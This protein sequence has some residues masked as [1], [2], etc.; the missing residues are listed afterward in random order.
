MSDGGYANDEGVTL[1]EHA[2]AFRKL[3]YLALLL[4]LVVGC[5]FV[6]SFKVQKQQQ[7][8]NYVKQRM[9][10]AQTAYQNQAAQ[11][12]ASNSYLP[13]PSSAIQGPMLNH[14]ALVTDGLGKHLNPTQTVPASGFDVYYFNTQDPYRAVHKDNVQNIALTINDNELYDI[15]TQFMGVYWVGTVYAP[16][17]GMYDIAVS[18]SN[19][20][21]RALLDGRVIEEDTTHGALGAYVYLNQGYYKFELEFKNNY[22][23]VD[24][25]AYFKKHSQ[26]YKKEALVNALSGLGIDNTTPLYV[27]SVGRAKNND[28]TIAV[29]SAINEPYVLMLS[30]PMG[31]LWQVYGQPP[32]AIIHN[33]RN[34]VQSLGSPYL[35]ESAIHLDKD[36][37]SEQVYCS[38]SDNYVFYCS[39]YKDLKQTMA[40]I[41]QWTGLNLVG[42]KSDFSADVIFLPDLAVNQSLIDKRHQDFLKQQNQC[43]PPLQD[44]RPVYVDP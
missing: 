39:D 32:R 34:Q 44:V 4:S 13:V 2:S 22:H 3:I 17:N 10:A 16:T 27:V 31:T 41:N 29:H 14:F 18:S 30:A 21:V 7:Q 40:Q 1:W 42:G 8:L 28:K 36:I 23:S 20:S 35:L 5:G 37:L 25:Y 19:S 12:T 38:C 43:R 26:V 9:Q 6:M 11:N 33:Q 24:T 15:P